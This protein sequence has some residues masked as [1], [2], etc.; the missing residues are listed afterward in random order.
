MKNK[1]NYYFTVNRDQ[2][3][4]FNRIFSI[5]TYCSSVN[6]EHRCHGFKSATVYNLLHAN[7]KIPARKK[8]KGYCITC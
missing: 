5:V 8:E 1:K 4:T 6:R 2:D 7:Y 3:Y